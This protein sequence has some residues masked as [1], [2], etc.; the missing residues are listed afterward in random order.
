[1]KKSI[2]KERAFTLIELLVVISIIA[3]LMAITIPVT[4]LAR[5]VAKQTACRSNLRSIGWALRMYLDDNSNKMPSAARLPS[6]QLDDKPPITNFLKTYLKDPRIFRC[7]ADKDQKYFLSE[8]SSYEYNASLGGQPVSASWMARRGEN[9]INIQV[10]YDYK[11]FH[12]TAGKP[13][14]Y[15]YL[16][17]DG[18]VGDLR[19]QD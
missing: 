7:P 4:T 6:A 3:L 14:A 18:H 12:G 10:M 9:E 1:M 2:Y 19:K 17:A 8:G 15:N 16:Y 11:A 13:G 5:G